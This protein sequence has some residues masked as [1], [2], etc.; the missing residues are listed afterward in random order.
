MGKGVAFEFSTSVVRG[1][2]PVIGKFYIT[3]KSILK[4]IKLHKR[5][6]EKPNFLHKENLGHS[7][8]NLKFRPHRNVIQTQKSVQGISL[9]EQFFTVN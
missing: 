6:W 8:K 1:L 5:G 4:K 7:R 9:L 3:E 2:S